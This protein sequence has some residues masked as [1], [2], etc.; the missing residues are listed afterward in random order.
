MITNGSKATKR[1]RTQACL[2]YT[3][4]PLLSPWIRSKLR[5][6]PSGIQTSSSKIK[7]RFFNLGR[8]LVHRSY[9]Q[10]YNHRACVRLFVQAIFLSLS[11]SHLSLYP[12]SPIP[13]AIDPSFNHPPPFLLTSELLPAPAPAPEEEEILSGLKIPLEPPPPPPAPPAPL[14]PIR[15]LLM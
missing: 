13:L 6:L 14:F 1:I 10:S 3:C 9:N 12:Q 4:R 2:L 11:L 8:N 5:K 7:K 15:G